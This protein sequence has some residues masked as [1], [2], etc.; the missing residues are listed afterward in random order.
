VEK[1]E[2]EFSGFSPLNS[3]CLDGCVRGDVD[4]WAVVGDKGKEAASEM[5]QGG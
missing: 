3:T 2:A 4:G 1:K 5:G